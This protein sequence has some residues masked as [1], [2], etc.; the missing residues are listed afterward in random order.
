MIDERLNVN[1]GIRPRV[2]TLHCLHPNRYAGYMDHTLCRYRQLLQSH[3]RPSQCQTIIR[4]SQNTVCSDG[5]IFTLRSGNV[6]ISI[7]V[8]C[9]Y[10]GI[11]ISCSIKQTSETSSNFSSAWAL[12]TFRSALERPHPPLITLSEPPHTDSLYPLPHFLFH[13]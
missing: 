3:C 2:L 12:Y 10:S 5:D 13:K 7:C 4:Q 6:L 1:V 9:F 8:F 11:G